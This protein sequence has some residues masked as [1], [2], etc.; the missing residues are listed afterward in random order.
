MRLRAVVIVV[1][2][3]ACSTAAACCC[4]MHSLDRAAD[5]MNAFNAGPSSSRGR[6]SGSIGSVS[7]T[8]PLGP[9]SWVG[10]PIGTTDRQVRFAT[11]SSS[12]VIALH[13]AGD[14][15]YFKE[16]GEHEFVPPN[17]P[18]GLV[19][20][21][22]IVRPLNHP[23]LVK[24]VLTIKHGLSVSQVDGSVD[25]EFAGGTKLRCLAELAF[26][27]GTIERLDLDHSDHDGHHHHHH[28]H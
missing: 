11:Q 14:P 20:Q 27:L 5:K 21:W 9:A 22:E 4:G 7:I 26:V 16:N 25:L 15:L 17:D 13:L 28:H 8:E 19:T 6:C 12:L 2:G 23:A 10:T 18:T 3:L 1:L 24:G